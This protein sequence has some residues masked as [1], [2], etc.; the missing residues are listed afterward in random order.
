MV[1]ITA[2]KFSVQLRNGTDPALVGQIPSGDPAM[3]ADIFENQPYLHCLRLHG[4]AQVH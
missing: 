2:E 1:Q 4:Y 3:L